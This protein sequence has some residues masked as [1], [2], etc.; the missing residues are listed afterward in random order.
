[1][2]KTLLKGLQV[3][4]HVVAADQPI[5]SV[6]VARD[7][8]L[9]NSNANRVLKTLEHAGYLI[10]NPETREYAGSLKL[11]EL[12]ARIIDRVDLRKSA[13]GPLG[14]LAEESGEA[15]HLSVL[16][17]TEVI[18]LDKID[19]PQPIGAY[20]RTGG[21]APAHCVAT[22][23]ALLACLPDTALEPVLSDLAAH[24]SRTITDAGAFAAELRETRRR[25]YSINRGEWRDTVWGL[26]SVVFDAQENP[27]AAIGVSG[28]DFRLSDP[29]RL[30]EMGQ[31]VRRY[32]ALISRNLGNRGGRLPP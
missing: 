7:L 30:E 3:L 10:Q 13:A 5:R 15:V 9:M 6:Q 31:A 2:D 24:S 20:T 32:A 12:G 8:G 25:G 23:K 11:W 16:D 21:R 29:D 26:A 19:S 1:M 4:E 22:G 18:Y 28:P 14:D 17:G 27:V